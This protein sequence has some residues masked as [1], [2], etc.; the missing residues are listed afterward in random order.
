[1]LKSCYFLIS[2]VPDWIKTEEM[3][4]SYSRECCNVKVCSWLLQKSKICNKA[5]D[6]Y[7]HVLEF[8]FDYCK[9]KKICNKA[10][11]TYPS[12]INFFP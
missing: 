10:I 11:N 5:V 8:V 9:A 7:A 12:G 4:E 3:W 1:M 2:Y 6:I